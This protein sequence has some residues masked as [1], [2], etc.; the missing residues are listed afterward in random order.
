MIGL[1]QR[2]LIGNPCRLFARIFGWHRGRRRSPGRSGLPEANWE[3]PRR[4]R[5]IMS[6]NWPPSHPGLF[7]WSNAQL[8]SGSNTDNTSLNQQLATA[9]APCFAPA[10]RKI[11]SPRRRSDEDS[12]GA[13]TTRNRGRTLQTPLRGLN[14][15]VSANW[16]LLQIPAQSPQFAPPENRNQSGNDWKRAASRSDKPRCWLGWT[17]MLFL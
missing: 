14:A 9:I 4:G 11:P 2:C 16:T 13:N 10:S 15:Q 6:M 1:L 8:V 17:I 5:D 7:G 12:P 3:K